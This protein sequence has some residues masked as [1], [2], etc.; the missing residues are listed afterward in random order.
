[1]GDVP[2]SRQ[3]S[4][5]IPYELNK[6]KSLEGQFLIHLGDIRDSYINQTLPCPE[7]MF[8]NLTSTFSSSPVRTFFIPGERGL[9][10]CPSLSMALGYWDDYLL[11][12]TDRTDLGWPEFPAQVT[13]HPIRM[14]LF[15]FVMEEI[16]FLGQSLPGPARDPQYESNIRDPLLE[17]NANWAEQ[18]LLDY[19]GQYMAVVVFGND[20]QSAVNKDYLEKVI[21]L[22]TNPD[23]G[24]P[25]MLLLQNG[26]SFRAKTVDTNAPNVM[27]ARTDD[28][29]TPLAIT[30]D[31]WAEELED[32]FQFDRRC[33]CTFGHRPTRMKTYLPWDECAGVCDE[34]K[35]ECENVQSCSPPGNTC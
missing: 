3:E 9:L 32:I 27:W 21:S 6:L 35:S 34:A 15:S 10:D 30:V 19:M 33:Y 1:M 13:R 11:S 29:V 23:Y 31:P 2:F 20:F 28:T 26:N 22:A 17:D 12:F 14:E 7:S 16:L 18:A 24:E 25:P 5:L 8:A 4:C